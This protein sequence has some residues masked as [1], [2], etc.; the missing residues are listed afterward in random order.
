MKWFDKIRYNSYLMTLVRGTSAYS[1]RYFSPFAIAT[2]VCPVF[3][4][5]CSA[6]PFAEKCGDGS[7]KNE[8][9]EIQGQFSIQRVIR[10]STN[11]I[12]ENLR[13][14]ENF[15]CLIVSLL[16][17]IFFGMLLSIFV[18]FYGEVE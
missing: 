17:S 6:L 14:H 10:G 11:N 4:C 7:G 12:H 9:P 1:R 8:I 13:T 18:H 5:A 3:C 2:P 16:F 15:N